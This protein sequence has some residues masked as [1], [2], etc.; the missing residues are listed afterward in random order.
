ML[1]PTGTPL[2]AVT[3]GYAEF[4]TNTLAATPWA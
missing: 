1:G 3:S 2:V 4:K